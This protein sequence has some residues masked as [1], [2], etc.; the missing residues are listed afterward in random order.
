[1]EL[2]IV[3]PTVR[4]RSEIEA[5]TYLDQCSFEDYEVIIRDDVP[6]TRARNEGYRRANAEKI[7]FLDDD[8]MPREGYLTE[9]AATLEEADAVVGRTVH[10]RDDVFAG[11]LT[12]HYDFGSEPCSVDYFWGCNMG[13]RVE[14]LDAVGGWDETMGWGHE[15]KELADRVRQKYEIRYNPDMVV[16]H[17]YAES[18]RDYWDKMYHLERGTPHYLR[19]KGLPNTRIL[20]QA[21]SELLSP[22]NYLRRSPKVTLAKSGATVATA[23]GRFA[24]LADGEFGTEADGPTRS[25]SHSSD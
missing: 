25:S 1:M 5:I 18:I 8:S 3:I 11:Q 14:A 19:K 12:N 6:V 16:D 7:I 22:R 4:S 24:G 21:I 15:E 10:P 23:V 13:M 20:G 2:S 17:V 9:A